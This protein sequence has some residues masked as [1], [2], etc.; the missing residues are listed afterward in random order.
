MKFSPFRFLIIPALSVAVS[1]ADTQLPNAVYSNNAVLTPSAPG[2]DFW[3]YEE[4]TPGNLALTNVAGNLQSVLGGHAGSPGGNVELF[5][6]SEHAVYAD[7]SAGGAFASASPVTLAGSAGSSVFSFRSLN[8]NDW[9]SSASGF[10]NIYGSATL[11]TAWFDGFIDSVASLMNPVSAAGLVSVKGDLFNNWRDSGG[12]AS[13]SDANIGYIYESTATGDLNFGLE[14]FADASPRFRQFLD[15]AGYGAF[16]AFVPDGIQY[17]EVV[18]L[19]GEAYYSFLNATPSGVQL[20]DVPF[21]SYT[22][23]FAFV[24][25]VP[26][27]SSLLL[28]GAAGG[29]AVLRRR[30]QF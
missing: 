12:F 6:T 14:G 27:P 16:V 30:R 19:D 23:D 24:K 9:F 1:Q 7:S 4:T 13:L 10:S 18:M 15:D 26:E 22:A 3:I 11:A 21:N 17:S 28:I 29:L 20:D 5:P 8:G 2:T 25:T